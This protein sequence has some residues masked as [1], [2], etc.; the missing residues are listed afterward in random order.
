MYVRGLWI[1]LSLLL[2]LLPAESEKK[3]IL[4]AEKVCCKCCFILPCGN[5][6]LNQVKLLIQLYCPSASAFKPS[7]HRFTC[8]CSLPNLLLCL[9]LTLYQLELVGLLYLL[10]V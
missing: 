4:D 6:W 8:T 3:N 1:V 7:P 9:F 2:L 5:I 10:N